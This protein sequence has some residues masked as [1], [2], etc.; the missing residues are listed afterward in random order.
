M[1][2]IGQHFIG[3]TRK[4]TKYTVKGKDIYLTEP[5]VRDMLDYIVASQQQETL[6]Y[7]VI[8]LMIRDCCDKDGNHI[9]KKE[10]KDNIMSAPYGD[11]LDEIMGIILKGIR[12]KQSDLVKKIK[13]KEAQPSLATKA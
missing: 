11:G 3:A 9:F 13:P 7:L 5:S 4:S 10:Q 2:D 1:N 6:N 8:D 12:Q